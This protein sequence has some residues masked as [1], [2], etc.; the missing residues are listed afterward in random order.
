M[1][2]PNE[3]RRAAGKY[4][5]RPKGKIYN[6]TRRVHDEC[7]QAAA[8]ARASYALPRALSALPKATVGPNSGTSA[9]ESAIV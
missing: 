9:S 1:G 2:W 5:K 6:T 8:E 4:N 7:G 3:K